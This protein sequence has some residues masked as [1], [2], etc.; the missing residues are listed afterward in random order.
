MCV[1]CLPILCGHGL[2]SR[3]NKIINEQNINEQNAGMVCGHDGRS[4][5][6]S[7]ECCRN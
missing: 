1:V 2:C 4:E 5:V 6:K 7:N 3:L